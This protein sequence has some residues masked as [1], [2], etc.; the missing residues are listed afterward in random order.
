M[1]PSLCLRKLCAIEQLISDDKLAH[2]HPLI[3][4]VVFSVVLWFQVSVFVAQNP[5]GVLNM[6]QTTEIRPGLKI[7]EDFVI[8]HYIGMQKL[9]MVFPALPTRVA[10]MRARDPAAPIGRSGLPE[11]CP[12]RPRRHDS[13]STGANRPATRTTAPHLTVY[14]PDSGDRESRLGRVGRPGW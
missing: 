9:Y 11:R 13:S 6:Y 4:H 10:D 5:L 8:Q 12:D 1:P 3:A 2:G 14:G 7:E